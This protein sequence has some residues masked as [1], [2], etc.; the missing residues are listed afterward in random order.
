[1][2][3]LNLN[4][5]K[6]AFNTFFDNG[7]SKTP[8]NPA[9]KV[10]NA[11]NA[12]SNS[13]E[14][15]K[16]SHNSSSQSDMSV[17]EAQQIREQELSLKDIMKA[18]KINFSELFAI[19]D[20]FLEKGYYKEEHNIQGFKFA[21][22][23]KT[24]NTL[25]SI[26]NEMDGSGAISRPT[27]AQLLLRKSMAASLLYVTRKDHIVFEARPDE[28]DTESYR[29]AYEALGKLHVPLYTIISQKFRDFELRAV[30][31]AREDVLEHFLARTQG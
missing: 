14:I 12:Q 31:A 27:A 28:T 11:Q 29:R 4:S 30:L 3:D 6:E 23:N 24:V 21:F 2:E 15:N 20:S 1:M 25:S 16:V 18:N 17:E 13:P 9:Q 22:R 26:S 19:I 5:A 10:L 8:D 7:A